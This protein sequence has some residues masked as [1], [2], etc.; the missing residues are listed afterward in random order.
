MRLMVEFHARQLFF[1][2]SLKKKIKGWP[3]AEKGWQTC[4]L[5]FL[6]FAC[7]KNSYCGQTP[8]HIAPFSGVQRYFARLT[9]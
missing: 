4:A 8:F 5:F 9:V 6:Y 1:A 3:R 2:V 7:K